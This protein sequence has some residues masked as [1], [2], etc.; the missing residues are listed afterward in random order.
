MWESPIEIICGEMRM[1][2]EEN[3]VKAVQDYQI[4]VNREELIKA[5]RYDRNSYENGYVDAFNEMIFELEQ[6]QADAPKTVGEIIDRLQKKAS[7]FKNK[8]I[9]SVGE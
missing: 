4:N 5:L 1:Q 9:G 2:T 6:G 3:V 8:Y 7:K